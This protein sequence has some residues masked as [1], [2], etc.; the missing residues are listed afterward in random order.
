MSNVGIA[1]VTCID[2]VT[3]TLQEMRQEAIGAL[4]TVLERIDPVVGDFFY[5]ISIFDVFLFNF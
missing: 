5:Y 3:N 4:E 1:P 2:D